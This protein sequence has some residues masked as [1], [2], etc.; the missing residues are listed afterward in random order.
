MTGSRLA[1][2]G[3]NSKIH[4]LHGDEILV[5]APP[6]CPARHQKLSQVLCL[7]QGRGWDTREGVPSREKRLGDG[8][9]V[10]GQLVDLKVFRSNTLY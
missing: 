5:R 2:A 10:V 7:R 3:R 8:E 9:A 6:V 1:Q 4:N